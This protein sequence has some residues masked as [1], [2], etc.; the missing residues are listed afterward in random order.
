[1]AACYQRRKRL[2]SHT[3]TLV[4]DPCQMELL[5]LGAPSSVLAFFQVPGA[6]SNAMAPSFSHAAC[7]S[8]IAALVIA[9]R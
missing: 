4:A 3:Y 5:L 8:L 2:C 6:S 9:C 7:S 1:M